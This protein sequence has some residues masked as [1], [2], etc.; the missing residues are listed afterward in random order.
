M[1]YVKNENTRIKGEKLKVRVTGTCNTDGWAN[2]YKQKASERAIL[3]ERSKLK[4][5][6]VAEKPAL[7]RMVSATPLHHW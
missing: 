3:G 6:E 4:R 5:V 1:N 2:D 7:K